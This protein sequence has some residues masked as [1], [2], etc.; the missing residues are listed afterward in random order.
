MMSTL[1]SGVI[2]NFP[3]LINTGDGYQVGTQGEEKLVS[4][5]LRIYAMPKTYYTAPSTVAVPK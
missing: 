2:W 5:R 3:K 4:L 1:P